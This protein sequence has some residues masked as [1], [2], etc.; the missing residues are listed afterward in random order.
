MGNFRIVSHRMFKLALAQMRVDGGCRSAN[1]ERAISRIEA[2]AAAGAQVV[3]L[4]ETMDLGWTH[5]AAQTEAESIPDGFAC[6]RLCEAARRHGL[7]LCAGLVERRGSAVY[8]AAVLIGPD[9]ELL[10]HHRKLNE[11][12]I[13]HAIYLQGDRLGVVSTPL[14]T[15]GVMIC[16]DAFARGQTLT[17]TLGLMGAD[18]ILSPCAWAVPANHDQAVEPYGQLWLDNY[19]PVARDFQLWI[20]GVSNVG[21]LAAGP[22]AGR[23]CIGCSL[24]IGPGGEIVASGPYGPDADQIIYVEVAPAPRPARGAGWEA[25]WHQRIRGAQ[26]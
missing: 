8:N 21:W 20:A 1:I 19:Q 15:F 6:A 16:A 9:G 11:L 24:V 7:Y 22:W 23:K 4:P 5:P 14:A 3:L 18:I 25:Y 10:L 12:E 2:A 17:R 26:R 13:A